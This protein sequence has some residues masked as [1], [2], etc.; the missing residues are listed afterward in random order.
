V[1]GNDAPIVAFQRNEGAGSQALIKKLVM[2]ETEMTKAPTTLIASEMGELME[3]VK[4]YDNSANAIGYSVYYYANDM[5]KADG[6]KLISVDGVEPSAET[7]RERSYPHLNAYYCV[8]AADAEKESPARILYEWMMSKDGQKLVDAEGYV[9]AKDPDELDTELPGGQIVKTD[10]TYY[11][12]LAIPENKFTRLS[13]GPMKELEARDDYGFIYPYSGSH[14]YV[15]DED[16]YS[17]E[18]GAMK[19]FFDENARLITD[20]VYNS[21]DVLKYYDNLSGTMEDAPIWVFSRALTDKLPEY[22][23]GVYEPEME[24]SFATMDGSFVCDKWY[25]FVEVHDDRI[26]CTTMDRNSFDSYDLSGNKMLSS[27]QTEAWKLDVGKYESGED[28]I[29][30]VRYGDGLYLINISFEESYYADETGKTVLGPY[31]NARVFHDGKAVAEG[32]GEGEGNHFGVINKKGEWIIDPAYQYIENLMNGN[33]VCCKDE[34]TYEVRDT[35]GKLLN[36]VEARFINKTNFG[37]TSRYSPT[38]DEDK[39]ETFSC[40][41]FEGNLLFRDET[42]QWQTAGCGEILS[43]KMGAGVQLRNLFTGKTIYV[44]GADDATPFYRF[45]DTP[46][47]ERVI[48]RN[49]YYDDEAEYYYCHERVYDYDLEKLFDYTGGSLMIERDKYNGDWYVTYYVKGNKV[50]INDLDF[51]EIGTIDG[52]PE[53]VNEKFIVSDDYAC[54]CYDKDGNIIFSYSMLKSMGD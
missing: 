31:A 7:I 54:T 53:I 12:K 37:F 26:I 4:G 39:E 20:P 30:D 19:G 3:A 25:L 16:G 6:L 42:G 9:A 34:T 21:I 44:E 5:K 52:N 28:W 46:D 40:Y 36:T 15:D 43:R 50:C 8:I 10:Y 45:E 18:A 33:F 51:N 2:K 47:I 41:D 29:R 49:S 24:Y 32:P 22:E 13:D 11:R 38:E 48:A 14:N 23:E 35:D 17:Y 27:N 1:G